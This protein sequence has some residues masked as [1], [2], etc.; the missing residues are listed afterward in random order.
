MRKSVFLHRSLK[1]F[2]ASAVIFLQSNSLLLENG[3]T[4]KYIVLQSVK[5]TGQIRYFE[6]FS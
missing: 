5:T 1:Q 2:A 6:E 4:G 3:R